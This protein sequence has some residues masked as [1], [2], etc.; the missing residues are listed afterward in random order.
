[1]VQQVIACIVHTKDLSSTL[2]IH[3]TQL[4]AA[5]SSSSSRCPPPTSGTCTYTD[6]YTCTCKISNNKDI[7]KEESWRG[8]GKRVQWVR[9]LVTKSGNLSSVPRIYIVEVEKQ[10]S[11]MVLCPPHV[12]HGT[13]NHNQSTNQLINIKKYFKRIT[14]KQVVLKDLHLTYPIIQLRKLSIS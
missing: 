9:A 2:S 4:T 10:L 14:D 11:Q 12:H 8:V 3:I 1:M 6:I 7:F 13:Q 5:C